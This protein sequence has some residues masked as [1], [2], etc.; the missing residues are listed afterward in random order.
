MVHSFAPIFDDALDHCDRNLKNNSL[1]ICFQC[2]NRRWFIH[3]DFCFYVASKKKVQIH[4]IT[5]T[6]YHTILVA[7]SPGHNMKLIA[8]QND[9]PIIAL[10]RALCGKWHCLV[11]TKYRGDHVIQFE[12]PKSML[13]WRDNVCR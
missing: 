3:I 10:L 7:N 11:R 1:N 6:K 8:H 5:N 13:P 12:T 4:S 2:F 9:V